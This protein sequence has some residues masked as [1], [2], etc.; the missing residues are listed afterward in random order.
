MDESDSDVF[1]SI[2]STALNGK[3][4]YKIDMQGNASIYAEN[5]S[6]GPIK[7]AFD[8][9][10]NLFVRS[11]QSGNVTK[12]TPNGST[13]TFATGLGS[14]G[15]FGIDKDDNIFTL[16]PSSG[17]ITKIA[18]DGTKSDFITD[19]RVRGPGVFFDENGDMF[20][21][22]WWDGYIMKIDPQGNVTQVAKFSKVGHITYANGYIYATE[23]TTNKIYKVSKDGSEIVHIAGA[24]TN[25]STDGVGLNASFGSPNGITASSDGKF[26]FI[27]ET[28]GKRSLRKIQLRE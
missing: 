19:A 13:S 27:S 25:S 6:A 24:G 26:L 12:I 3:K 10:G 4:I 9:N 17:K 28:T 7:N 15:G 5:I 22:N 18:P 1:G 2:S 14:G 8:S 16:N 20:V 23:I 11:Y 21:G